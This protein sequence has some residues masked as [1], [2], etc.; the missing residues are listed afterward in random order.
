MAGKGV[1]RG[2]AA[3]PMPSIMRVPALFCIEKTAF[4][5]VLELKLILK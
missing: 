4:K 2:V 5:T 1:M 3:R